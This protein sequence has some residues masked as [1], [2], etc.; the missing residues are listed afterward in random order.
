[1]RLTITFSYNLSNNLQT[2]VIISHLELHLN[3]ENRDSA[4]SFEEV[5]DTTLCTNATI[6]HSLWFIPQHEAELL[7][8]VVEN[9]VV[10]VNFRRHE[11]IRVFAPEKRTLILPLLFDAQEGRRTA[12]T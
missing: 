7:N 5:L 10:A 12:L 6:D 1:M 8:Q 4:K 11:R 9:L 3:T 2:F